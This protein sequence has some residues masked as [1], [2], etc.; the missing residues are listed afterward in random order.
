[1][2]RKK[3]AE[4]GNASKHTEVNARKKNCWAGEG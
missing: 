1:M 4:Q 2:L 3:T